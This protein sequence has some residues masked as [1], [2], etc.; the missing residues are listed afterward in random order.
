VGSGQARWR[1]A[2]INSFGSV[3]PEILR[4]ALER[5]FLGVPPADE[6]SFVRKE[7]T[8]AARPGGS[9]DSYSGRYRS[10]FELIAAYD[11]GLFR[12]GSLAQFGIDERDPTAD[13]RLV[14][15]SFALPPEQ[16]LHDGVWRPLAKRALAD[17]LPPQILNSPVRGYQGADWYERIDQDQALQLLEEIAPSH[18]VNEL[19]DVGKMRSAIE[20][21]PGSGWAE[22]GNI[23]LYRTRLPVALAT[24]VFLQLFEPTIGGASAA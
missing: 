12:K 3:V 2:L 24:G 19:L 7:W 6:L 10:R 9:D 16:L 13:R 11:P 14:D 18:A 1:G 15:Y 23:L 21:W 5:R 20:R 22:P 4:G 17:L 8:V